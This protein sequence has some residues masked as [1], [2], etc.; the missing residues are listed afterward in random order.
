MLAIMKSKTRR[1]GWPIFGGAIVTVGIAALIVVGAV[2]QPQGAADADSSG[3]SAGS[4]QEAVLD[5]S[6]RQVDDPT[7]LGSVDAPVVLVEYADYRC[8]FCGT[9]SR[10]SMPEL[11]EEY[12]DSGKLRIEWRDLPIFGDE[13]IGAAV[14]A[15]AA[16]NQGKFWEY[17]DAIFAAAPERGHPPLPRERLLEFAEKVG[18]PDLAK[19]TS[20]LDDKTL[21]DQ[22]KFDVAEAAALGA[23]STPVFLINETPIAGAQPTDIFRAAIDAAI[24]KAEG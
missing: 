14:A 23:A 21:H 17:H 11:V 20:D 16:G 8:P 13:S 1:N 6:R 15:R 24:T 7:A 4:G 3:D 18:V 19:F 22:V 9:F 10:D 5:M 2:N 12:V